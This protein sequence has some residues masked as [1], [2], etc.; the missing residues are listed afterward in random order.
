M[1]ISNLVLPQSSKSRWEISKRRGGGVE[2]SVKTVQ[3]SYTWVSQI[4]YSLKVQNIDGKSWKGGGRGEFNVKTVQFSYIWVSQ[5]LI[6]LKVQNID[7]K[8]QKEK[9]GTENYKTSKALSKHT[10]KVLTLPLIKLLGHEIAKTNWS[11]NSKRILWTC[12]CVSFSGSF[13]IGV[14]LASNLIMI[15]V[16]IK[17]FQPQTI[18]ILIPL[19]L[20]NPDSD[21]GSVWLCPKIPIL[22]SDFLVFKLWFLILWCS[23]YEK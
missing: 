1:G 4:L 15:L 9:R 11:E 23:D 12:T 13:R 2:F 8:S 19:T 6:S 20:I 16:L 17:G 7:G 5:I 14:L 21:S 18:L 10:R 22:I 3:F